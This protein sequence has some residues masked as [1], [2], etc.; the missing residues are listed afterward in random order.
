M[1]W[2]SIISGFF[3]PALLLFFNANTMKEQIEA[4]CGLVLGSLLIYI[5]QNRNTQRVK[6]WLECF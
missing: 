1:K 4:L 2:L 5:S 3:L 6:R